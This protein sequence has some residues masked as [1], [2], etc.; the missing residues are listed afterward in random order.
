MFYLRDNPGDL[1]GLATL[2]GHNSLDSTRSYGQPTSEMLAARLD[3]LSL[4][5]YV[6]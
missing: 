1:I 2:L 3:R 5:S 6:E 4:N